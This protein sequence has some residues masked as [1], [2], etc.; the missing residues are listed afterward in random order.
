MNRKNALKMPNWWKI[1]AAAAWL[2]ATAPFY[3]L[4]IRPQFARINDLQK[5]LAGEIALDDLPAPETVF[6]LRRRMAAKAGLAPGQ[7]PAGPPP[8]TLSA[9]SGMARGAGVRLNF[10]ALMP[11]LELTRGGIQLS[12]YQVLLDGSYPQVADFLHRLEGE[13]FYSRVSYLA[14][15]E[16]EE[17]Q[18]AELNLSFIA[19]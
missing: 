6:A 16:Q 11:G 17:V 4:L 2:A 1:A 18:R 13:P 3:L 19:R 8:L 10:I 9:V 15:Q 7:Q 12:T 14:I 5:S